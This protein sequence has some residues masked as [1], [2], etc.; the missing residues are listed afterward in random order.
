MNSGDVSIHF[1]FSSTL[2]VAERTCVDGSLTSHI[3]DLNVFSPLSKSG[4]KLQRLIVIIIIRLLLPDSDTDFLTVTP[5]VTVSCASCFL[6]FSTVF[7]AVTMTGSTSSQPESYKGD[8][9]SL[10]II[11]RDW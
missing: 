11:R 5:M 4:R 9:W 8:L 2:C 6:S 3:F 7:L 1:F 10:L